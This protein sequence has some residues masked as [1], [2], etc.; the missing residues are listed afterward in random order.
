MHKQGTKQGPIR[1]SHQGLV[2][3]TSDERFTK[4]ENDM[5]RLDS[6]PEM[7]KF[8]GRCSQVTEIISV[9]NVKV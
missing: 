2:V 7:I 1:H 8:V 5:I 6:M 4:K 9:A 3:Q